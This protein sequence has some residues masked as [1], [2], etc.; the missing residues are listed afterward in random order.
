MRKDRVGFYRDW[1][2]R[3]AREALAAAH[4]K[5]KERCTNSAA[6]WCSIADAIEAGDDRKVARLTH[7]LIF[8]N[9]AYLVPC[10]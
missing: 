5:T 6:A 10:G 8:L 1:A 9:A 2:S 3:A 7:N 4:M